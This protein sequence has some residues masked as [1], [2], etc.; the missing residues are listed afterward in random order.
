MELSVAVEQAFRD[1]LERAYIDYFYQVRTSMVSAFTIMKK[2]SFAV[3]SYLQ[4]HNV[5]EQDMGQEQPA[6][7]DATAARQQLEELTS[8]VHSL[9]TSLQD[10]RNQLN[11]LKDKKRGRKN[12]SGRTQQSDRNHVNARSQQRSSNQDN[13]RTSPQNVQ[14]Q[15]KRNQGKKQGFNKGKNSNVPPSKTQDNQ[16][17]KG[18]QKKPKG[19]QNKNG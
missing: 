2:R 1:Q 16:K 12:D 17:K 5:Q 6:V 11:Q 9:R 8:Q 4:R 18:K 15:S 7:D 13:E 19:K 10:T 14:Q 3:R